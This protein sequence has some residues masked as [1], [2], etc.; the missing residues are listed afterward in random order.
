MWTHIGAARQS[1]GHF[2]RADMVEENERA[3]H[4]M[5]CGRQH[6]AHFQQPQGFATLLDDLIQHGVIFALVLHRE[7]LRTIMCDKRNV[8]EG[9]W[10]RK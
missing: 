6:P 7:R 3:D 1:R 4:A 2:D 10:L 8:D 5:S 9:N